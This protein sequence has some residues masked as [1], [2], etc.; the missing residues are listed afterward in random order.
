MLI[1]DGVT[2]SDVEHVKPLENVSPEQPAE[3]PCNVVEVRDAN[4]LTG[5]AKIT[6]NAKVR[7]THLEHSNVS[8]VGKLTNTIYVV[9]RNPISYNY[10]T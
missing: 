1:S 3:Q 7:S 6:S 9:N 2:V 10:T 4:L 5:E 8:G